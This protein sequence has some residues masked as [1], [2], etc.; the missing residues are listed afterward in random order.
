MMLID[1]HCHTRYSQDNL[2][3][4]EDLFARAIEMRLDGVCITEH[5]SYEASRPIMDRQ[6][7]DNLLVL[8][9]LEVSTDH[10]HLLVYGVSDDSWNQWGRNTSLS[11]SKVVSSVHALGGVCVP[12]HPYR[13]WD[14]LGDRV[15]SLTGIDALETHNGMNASELNQPAIKAALK[16]GLPSIGGSDCHRGNQVGRAFTEFFDEIRSMED[17]VAAVKAGRCRGQTYLRLQR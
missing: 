10:G 16:L 9:G 8:R 5:Y 7:P 15:F 2:L 13:G 6:P 14:S 12:A 3:E 1:L 17:L 4:P 11:F